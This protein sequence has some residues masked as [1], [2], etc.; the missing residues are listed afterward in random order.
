MLSTKI[1]NY[2]TVA[3]Y[4]VGSFLIIIPLTKYKT[5]TKKFS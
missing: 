3:S 5:F 1:A 2:I 4:F